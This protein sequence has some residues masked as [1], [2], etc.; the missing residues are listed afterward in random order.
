MNIHRRFRH[1]VLS[2][3]VAAMLPLA[4]PAGAVDPIVIKFSHVTASDTP[5]GKGADH[6]KQLVEER[7]QGRVKVEVYPN[8]TL[9]KDKEEMEALQLGSVQ[10]LAPYALAKI[11]AAGKTEVITLSTA[12]REAWRKAMLPVHKEMAS[13]VGADTLAAIAKEAAALGYK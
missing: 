6:F 4:G 1:I 12:E 7:T 11:K 10:M 2:T 3:A 9:Y 8:S 5:K 13:R